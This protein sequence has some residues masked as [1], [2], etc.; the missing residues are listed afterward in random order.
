[1]LSAFEKL[2]SSFL[3]VFNG[4]RAC[5]L[6]LFGFLVEIYSRLS[7]GHFSEMSS[8]SLGNLKRIT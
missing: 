6:F 7:V 5:H 8:F 3:L 2:K 1:M 4:L